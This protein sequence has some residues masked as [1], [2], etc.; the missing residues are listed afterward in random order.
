MAMETGAI[1]VT[2]VC[3]SH[4][5]KFSKQRNNVGK[6]IRSSGPACFWYQ[7]MFINNTFAAAVINQPEGLETQWASLS[8]LKTPAAQLIF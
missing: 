4:S 5:F 1:F 7:Q 6:W 2:F 8:P 3:E